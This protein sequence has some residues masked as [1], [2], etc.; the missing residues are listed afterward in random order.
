MSVV[1]VW[2]TLRSHRLLKAAGVLTSYLD[3]LQRMKE[4]D[5][6]LTFVFVLQNRT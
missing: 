1:S 6:S 3:G 5:V 2:S 4:G